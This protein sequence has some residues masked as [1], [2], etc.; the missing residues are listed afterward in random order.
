MASRRT[1]LENDPDNPCFGCGPHNRRGLHLRFFLENDR[2]VSEKSFS[3]AFSGWPGVVAPSMT[4]QALCCGTWWTI[5]GRRRRIGAGVGWRFAIT[6]LVRVGKP[7]RIIGRIVRDRPSE[8][9]ARVEVLQSGKVK[10]W[11]EQ[12]VRMTGG[13]SAFHQAFPDVRMTRAMSK[14]LPA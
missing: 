14:I 5:Y 10:G 9:T 13:R 4:L 6:G 1:E 8:V 2:V 7:V 11:M 12:R 3:S